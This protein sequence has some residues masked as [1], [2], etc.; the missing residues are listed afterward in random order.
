MTK[1]YWSYLA[2]AIVCEVVATSALKSAEGF[3]RWLPSLL[4]V[5]GYSAAF[6]FLSL[7][8]NGIPLGIAY[9]V[10]SGVGVALVSLLGYLWYGQTLDVPAMI[11]IALIILGVLVLNLYSNTA[12]T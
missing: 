5:T 2:T 6:Y 10:W 11:G 7:T 1:V 4:V 9:A 3:T 8:L 12:L